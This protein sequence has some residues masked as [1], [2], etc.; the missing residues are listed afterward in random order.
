MVAVAMAVIAMVADW[1]VDSVE[2]YVVAEKLENRT[3]VGG[4]G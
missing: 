3:E 1:I 4:T 2:S